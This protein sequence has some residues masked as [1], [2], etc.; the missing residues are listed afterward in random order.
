[1][2]KKSAAKGRRRPRQDYHDSFLSYT[3]VEDRFFRDG[4]GG[5]EEEE[6]RVPRSP[7]KN[8]F[9]SDPEEEEK[10]GHPDISR[11]EDLMDLVGE[12]AS[13][14]FRKTVRGRSDGVKSIST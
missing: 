12:D 5:L 6:V 4:F 7:L 10:K 9:F 13:T 8:G 1:M 3:D 14:M 11:K 2:L